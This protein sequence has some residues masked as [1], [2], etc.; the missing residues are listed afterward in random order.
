MLTTP[1]QRPSQTASGHHARTAAVTGVLSTNSGHCSAISGAVAPLWEP[2]TRCA[3]V[4]GAAPST[5]L[6]TP[7]TSSAA[8]PSNGMGTTLGHGPSLD[9]IK[10][11]PAGP[12]ERCRVKCRGRYPLQEPPCRPLELPGRRRN[13][14]EIRTLPRTTATPGAMLFSAPQCTFYSSHPLRTPDSGRRRRLDLPVHELCPS[15]CL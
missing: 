12:S 9:Q 15:L 13:L 14:R 5:V 8:G 1:P 2:A 4:H 7:C 6:P 3:N 10:T 11:P